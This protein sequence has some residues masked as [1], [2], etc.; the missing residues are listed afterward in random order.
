MVNM[1]KDLACDLHH[2]DQR[3]DDVTGEIET[4]AD[5]DE[6]C[7]RLRR[8]PASARSSPAPW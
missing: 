6:A 1:I 5:N 8:Y 2:L 3:I 7:Q 4:L